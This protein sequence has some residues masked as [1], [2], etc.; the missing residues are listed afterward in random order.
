MDAQLIALLGIAVGAILIGYVLVQ[1]RKGDK[2]TQLP[3]D[4]TGVVTLVPT[5]SG[6]AT[7]GRYVGRQALLTMPERI[8]Y[9]RLREAL[10]DKLIF[11][12]VAVNQLIDS[13]SAEGASKAVDFSLF[14]KISGK[15]FDF[16][17]CDENTAPL[18]AVELDDSSHQRSD[19]KKADAQKN[20]ACEQ[21]G[22]RLVRFKVSQMPATAELA[23]LLTPAKE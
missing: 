14:G 12:Q 4:G 1:V 13:K 3:K 20:E 15:S 16:V 19:R 23:N 21:A 2:E 11:S 7:K 5:E 17:V 9:Q 22:I 8:L 6:A 18:V 10:P